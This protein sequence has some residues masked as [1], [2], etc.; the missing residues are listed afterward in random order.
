MKVGKKMVILLFI[1]KHGH[2]KEEMERGGWLS[3]NGVS[4]KSLKDTHRIH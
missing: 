2:F 3:G 4:V 1:F